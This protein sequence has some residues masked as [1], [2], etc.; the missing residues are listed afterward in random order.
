MGCLMLKK[1]VFRFW[2]AKF[3][4]EWFR[5]YVL[6]FFVSNKKSEEE[7][8]FII[9][10]GRSGNTVLRRVLCENYDV[11]IPPENPF[12]YKMVRKAVFARRGNKAKESIGYF[13]SKLSEPRF[14]NL[15]D[16]SRYLIDKYAEF[17]L[18]FDSV[19][20]RIDRHFKDDIAT[21]FSSIY[22]E[23]AEAQSRKAWG[24]KT[25]VM[26]FNYPLM[27]KLYPRARFL[28]I[29]RDPVDC[30]SS[31]YS[32]MNI[33][34]EK[35]AARW[36]VSSKLA[37]KIELQRP[38]SIITVKY[39]DL[40]SDTEKTLCRVERFLNFDRL[41]LGAG[42]YRYGDDSVEMHEKSKKPLNSSS[43]GSGYSSLSNENIRFLIDVLA[44]E[45]ATFGYG[46]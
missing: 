19:V 23:N 28:F 11:A 31:Y 22:K 12:V 16:G 27:M 18:D 7:P 44:D 32:R 36:F 40:V 14:V 21:I 24:D 45:S 33:G 6:S 39:E 37:K 4:L 17:S 26:V 41:P 43:I 10:C 1:I 30:A 29:V 9:G 3:W 20:S 25:P 42:D 38:G 13:K 34:V 35:T 5:A 8:F 2:V 46:L 15:P